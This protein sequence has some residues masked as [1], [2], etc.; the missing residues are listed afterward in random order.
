ME[1][2]VEVSA[3]ALRE[4]LAA[5]IGGS[6]A[7]SEYLVCCKFNER[8]GKTNNLNVLISEYNLWAES[9]KCDH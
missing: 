8:T 7:I 3:D 5:V 6:V 1:N 2:K 4:L 9:K